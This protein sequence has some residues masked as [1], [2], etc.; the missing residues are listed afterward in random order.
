[1]AWWLFD[2]LRV[3]KD[4]YK[5]ITSPHYLEESLDCREV[6]TVSPGNVKTIPAPMFG[7]AFRK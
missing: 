3:I 7:A 1:M 5:C 6:C 4:K 2:H